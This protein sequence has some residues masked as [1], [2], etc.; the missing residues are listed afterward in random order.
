[1]IYMLYIYI[2]IS[3]SLSLNLVV[4]QDYVRLPE[5]MKNGAMCV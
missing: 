1:M 5:E 4:F 3:L 2:Y